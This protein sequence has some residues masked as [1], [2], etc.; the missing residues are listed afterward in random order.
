M[1]ASSLRPVMILG[2]AF[3]ACQPHRTAPPIAPAQV[4]PAGPTPSEFGLYLLSMTWEPNACC[5][6]RERASCAPLAGSFAATHLT[7]HG[8]WPN[9]TDEQSRGLPRAWPQYCGAYQHCERAE[10][11]SC[12]PGAAVPDELA[13]L[14]PGYVA[15]TGAFATHEWSKHGSCTKLSAAEYFRAELSAI[16]LAPRPT[17]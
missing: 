3:A 4:A 9:F 16:Y 12:A 1:Y 13:R 14:A 2:L 8:L 6:E 15:R 17:S 11:A 10:D 5:T 7:L